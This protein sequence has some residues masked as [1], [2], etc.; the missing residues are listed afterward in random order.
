[1]ARRDPIRVNPSAVPEQRPRSYDETRHE[2]L[3]QKVKQELIG[4]TPENWRRIDFKILMLAG[5]CEAQVTVLGRNGSGPLV[6]PAPELIETA[7]EL[8]S[9]MYRP[10]EGTWFGMRFMID[11]PG[12]SW[13]NYNRRFDPLW[14][15]PLPPG[16]W[17]RDLTVFPRTDD[18]VPHGSAR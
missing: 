8:R 6:E 15:P 14:D 9:I 12:A 3:L 7:A 16:E 10:G 4:A 17:D 11:P 13:V 18:A 1:M 2:E 5:A